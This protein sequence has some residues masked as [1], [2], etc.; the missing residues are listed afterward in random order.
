MNPWKNLTGLSS[1][2]MRIAA[3]LMLF[4]WFFNT[5]INFNLNQPQFFLATVFLVFGLLL[6]TG[7]FLR[8]HSLTVVSAIVLLILSVLQAYWSYNGITGVFAQWVVMSSVF[9]YFV[10]HGNK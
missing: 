3:I 9:F 4:A 2:L 8:K 6:F 1:W 5:F 7:G 10:T